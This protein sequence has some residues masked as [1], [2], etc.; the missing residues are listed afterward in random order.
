M[1]SK[2]QVE[3]KATSTGSTLVV[4]GPLVTLYA[5][6]GHRFSECH[7]ITREAGYF[8]TKADI[9]D[10][11]IDELDELRPCDPGCTC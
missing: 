11:L 7:I 8:A 3:R 2:Q 1:A 4:D 10:E 6:D 5:P 9:Y